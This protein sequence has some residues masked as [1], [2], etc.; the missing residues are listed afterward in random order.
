MKNILQIEKKKY[1]IITTM[2][3]ISIMI[4]T[5]KI[6]KIRKWQIIRMITMITD[7]CNDHK[8]ENKVED[9]LMWGMNLKNTLSVLGK[10]VDLE[11]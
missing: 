2:K 11:V 10:S 7:D 6:I 3:I 4:I 5:T 8:A 9:E 1:L